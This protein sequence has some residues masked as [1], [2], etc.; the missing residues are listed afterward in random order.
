MFQLFVE[1][2]PPEGDLVRGK[3]CAPKLCLPSH[4]T[5]IPRPTHWSLGGSGNL[6]VKVGLGGD[7]G[8]V[9]VRS[10]PLLFHRG[11]QVGEAQGEVLQK[12]PL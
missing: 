5:Q 9:S 12:A 8:G 2:L 1:G 4:G 3:Q 6:D 7:K 10:L 11:R